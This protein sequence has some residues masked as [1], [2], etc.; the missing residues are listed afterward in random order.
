MFLIIWLTVTGN[1]ACALITSL[2]T[3]VKATRLKR[4]YPP[5][6]NDI[7]LKSAIADL[8]ILPTDQC[9]RDHATFLFKAILD[10][11]TIRLRE[12]DIL[13]SLDK[14]FTAHQKIFSAEVER[15]ALRMTDEVTL[16]IHVLLRQLSESTGTVGLRGVR[17]ALR[18]YSKEYLRALNIFKRHPSRASLDQLFVSHDSVSSF[19]CEILQISIR[20][21]WRSVND[22]PWTNS[23]MTL[24]EVGNNLAAIRSVTIKHVVMNYLPVRAALNRSA[25]IGIIAPTVSL[26]TEFFISLFVLVDEAHKLAIASFKNEAVDDFAL[27]LD[28][29]IYR[30][31]QDVSVMRA[32]ETSV[33]IEAQVIDAWV[34]LQSLP[35]EVV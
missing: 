35:I 4:S 3:L 8:D 31:V 12:I 20:I 13:G 22:T 16:I 11:Q 19:V 9:F 17:T 33:S 15:E 25:R 10:I 6:P 7:A 26:I 28:K 1:V 29:K 23:K 2:D 34:D 18:G 14:L 24:L 5:Q 21:V 32:T 27:K 30:F